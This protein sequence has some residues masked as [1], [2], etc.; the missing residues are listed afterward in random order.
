MLAAA[1]EAKTGGRSKGQGLEGLGQEIGAAAGIIDGGL[2]LSSLIIGEA[3]FG[4]LVAEKAAEAAAPPLGE[5]FAAGVL[6]LVE[7]ATVL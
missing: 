7:G 1:R 4:R 6:P 2:K 3:S 5:P